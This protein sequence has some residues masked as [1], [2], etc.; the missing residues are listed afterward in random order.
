VLADQGRDDKVAATR[1]ALALYER[2]GNLAAVA[3]VRA[4]LGAA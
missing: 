2:K 3:A 1:R 4:L